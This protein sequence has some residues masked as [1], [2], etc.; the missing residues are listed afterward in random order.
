MIISSR[1]KNGVGNTSM[2]G[3]FIKSINNIVYLKWKISKK[4]KFLLPFGW[5]FYGT[6][7]LIRMA[8]GKR[9]KININQTVEKA[10][11]RRNIYKE[12]DLFETQN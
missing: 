9:D 4:L 10:S 1:G 7:Y 3:Q 12:F 8:F 5:L 2:L 11:E 6:R